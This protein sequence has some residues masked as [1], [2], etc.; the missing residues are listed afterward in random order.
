[1]MPNAKMKLLFVVIQPLTTYTIYPYYLSIYP[2]SVLPNGRSINEH[3]TDKSII[4]SV[5][6]LKGFDFITRIAMHWLY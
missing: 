6:L 4:T 3:T 2:S 5:S 1:M